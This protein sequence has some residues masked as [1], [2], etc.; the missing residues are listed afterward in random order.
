MKPIAENRFTITKALF[1]E[2]MLRISKDSYGK[3]AIKYSFVFVA[4][5][6]AMAAFLLFTGGTIGQ[7]LIY[8]ALV[9]VIIL[10]LNVFAPRSHAKK[11]WNALVNRYGTAMERRV[12]FYK[13]H[14]EVDGD[15]SPKTVTYQEILEVKEAKHLYVLIGVDKV[16][17]MVARDGFAY[18][19]FD[20]VLALI[21]SA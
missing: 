6:V 1:Y 9:S 3:A 4:I 18:G 10:W 11:G 8:L 16:G 7:A 21:K 14:L 17:V 15:C 20:E 13:D 19:D 12:R 5:W 2:G